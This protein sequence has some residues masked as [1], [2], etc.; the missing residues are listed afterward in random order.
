MSRRPLYRLSAALAGSLLVTTL[1][2]CGPDPS[3]PDP[4][5]SPEPTENT[6]SPS[7]PTDATSPSDSESH[8]AAAATGVLLK[9]VGARV[10]APE[11]W[12]REE[13]LVEFVDSAQDPTS[14]NAVTLSSVQ[15]LDDATLREL[16]E[17]GIEFGGYQD[18]PQILEPVV[19]NG[20][21]CYHV[22]GQISDVAAIEDIGTIHAGQIVTVTLHFDLNATTAKDRQEITESVW[23]SVEWV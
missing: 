19:I 23:A 2:G 4:S 5:G 9:G 3:E 18:E 15:S 11:G 21:E 12:K 22:A 6:S 17:A 16:A 8:S 10:R 7:E 13:Q 20:V 14:E 1:A